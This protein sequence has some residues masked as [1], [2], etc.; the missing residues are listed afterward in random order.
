MSL[1][2]MR[3][4]GIVTLKY[5]TLITETILC[6]SSLKIEKISGEEKEKGKKFLG[7]T[8][9]ARATVR[10][11]TGA[12]LVRGREGGGRTGGAGYGNFRVESL[13]R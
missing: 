7:E 12:N 5:M 6:R 2:T 9:L 1:E 10:E 4:R 8:S 13:N 11:I 3:R